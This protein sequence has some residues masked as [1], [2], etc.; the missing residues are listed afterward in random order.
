M[1]EIARG[2][3]AR[4]AFFQEPGT[5][6]EVARLGRG[7]VPQTFE[8]TTMNMRFQTVMKQGSFSAKN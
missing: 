4:H 5:L 1:R 2:R 6:E 7:M 8:G 3:S